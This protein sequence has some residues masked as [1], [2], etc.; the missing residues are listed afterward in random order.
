MARIT[1]LVDK[2]WAEAFKNK[3]VLGTLV[4]MP[5]LFMILPLFQAGAHAQRSC[6]GTK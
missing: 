5:I 4:F 3:M 2:E 6:F 1:T